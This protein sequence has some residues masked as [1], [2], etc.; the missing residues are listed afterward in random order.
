MAKVNKNNK[1]KNNSNLKDQVK[2]VPSLKK[3]YNEEIVGK[4]KKLFNYKE[5]YGSSKNSV[6]F[7]KYRFRGC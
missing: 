6:H 4:L 5:Y 2:Y 7:D 1:I 3:I